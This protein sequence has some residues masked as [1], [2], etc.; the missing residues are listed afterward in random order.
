MKAL[1]DRDVYG[2]GLLV[3][4][5]EQADAQDLFGSYAH[6]D[7]VADPDFNHINRET[8]AFAAAIINH[9]RLGLLHN[10]QIRYLV[11]L[12]R[13]MPLISFVEDGLYF[14]ARN[15]AY[16]PDGLLYRCRRDLLADVCGFGRGGYWILPG[17][18][19]CADLLL[20]NNRAALRESLDGREQRLLRQLV[21]GYGNT[22]IARSE[23][24]SIGIVKTRLLEIYQKLGV[25][26]RTQAA[27][28][29]FYLGY[30]GNNDRVI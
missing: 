23:N 5:Y 4:G 6:F 2:Q 13:S 20:G 8:D 25:E 15:C 14:D 29:G 9:K 22:E 7:L 12:S 1:E 11:R 10:T 18:I 28:I 16:V 30:D 19:R 26:T 24:I 3:V 17:K 27:I 21:A